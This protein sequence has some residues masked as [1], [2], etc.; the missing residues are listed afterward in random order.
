[1]RSLVLAAVVLSGCVL[2]E[3]DVT[4]AME[5]AAKACSVGYGVAHIEFS[6]TVTM[7][8]RDDFSALVEDPSL[9]MGELGNWIAFDCGEW[10]A[11]SGVLGADHDIGCWRP[12]GT[13]ATTT[14]RFGQSLE[15]KDPDATTATADW[16]GYISDSMSERAIF[17][18]KNASDTVPCTF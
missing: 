17:Q 9:K 14:V 6:V 12:P 5:S 2:D 3:E 7:S 10:T 18:L 1:M 13:P 11:W 4:P 16:A 15:L 8:Q